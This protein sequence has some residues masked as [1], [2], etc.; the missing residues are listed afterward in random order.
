MGGQDG[1]YQKEGDKWRRLHAG[2]DRVRNV[3]RARDGSLWIA[4]S[5]GVHRY[6]NGDWITNGIEEGLPSSVA[7]KV[8]QDSRGRIWAGTTRGLSLFNPGSDTDPP[9]VLMAD[10]QNA[11]EAPPGGKI[12][13]QFSGED[14]WKMTLPG[15]LLFSWRIDDGGWTP[16]VA[17]TAA[18]WEKLP[19]GPHRFEVRAMDRNGNISRRSAS[20]AFTVLLPWYRMRDFI[21]LATGAAAI[22][23]LLLTLAVLSY[24]KRGDLIRKLNLT[25]KLEHDQQSI[26]ERIARREALPE[27]LQRVVECIAENCPGST[28]ALV[29]N[30]ETIRGVFSQP[31]LPPPLLEA[32][33]KM[34]TAAVSTG[35][36]AGS[37][38]EWWR[39]IDIISPGYSTGRCRVVTLLSGD[40]E[41]A[42][43]VVLLSTGVNGPT[44]RQR[45]VP[46]AFAAIAAAGIENVRLYERLAYQARH[47]VLTGLPNRFCFDD[48]LQSA[49]SAAALNG[50]SLSLLYLDLDRFK[51]INDSLG[52]RAGDLFL[53]QVALRLSEAL[54][55][56]AVLA[57]IGGDEFTVLLETGADKSSVQRLAFAMLNSLRSPIQVEG[58]DLFASASVGASFFPED[59]VTP[60]ALQ[61]HAD[62]AMY[63]AK[64]RGRNCLEF[65]SAEMG[66][67]T[68]AAISL[69]QILR[70]ALEERHFELHYQ[71]QFTRAGALTGFEALLR[72]DDPDRG[73]IGPAEFIPIAEE[74]GLIVPIGAWVVREACRQLRQWQDDGLPATRMSVNISALEIV[75]DSFAD[76]V[77]AAL[78]GE[79]ID[80]R[81][82]ELE[83]TESAIIR[84]PTE[85][86]R[87]M[88][89]AALARN[90]AGYRR[91]RDGLFVLRQSA[92]SSAGHAEDRP[93]FPGG[94]S[95]GRGQ[96]PT[97]A[98]YCGSGAQ[99]GPDRDCRGC[100]DRGAS[101]Y[102]ARKPLR[103]GAGRSVWPPA[104]RVTGP[105]VTGCGA[106]GSDGA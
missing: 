35:S 30:H 87:Q 104:A 91:L 27:I 36:P 101:F 62:I 105:F 42:G 22:I 80:P 75:S 50:Q 34:T 69:E 90:P 10:D 45:G 3:I 103:C 8:F 66:S 70:R 19:A 2:L 92:K 5:T 11:R 43:V 64:A 31:D 49:V 96:S 17:E 25:N 67:V 1:L 106:C 52:H 61:K 71:P 53:A 84:N 37:S 82:L 93:L 29:L 23:I 98:D 57:R 81:F 24:R 26:L 32:L 44:D 33:I 58:Q 63:R 15:R 6:R 88:E 48:R 39:G 73:P 68:E 51:Q 78:S 77:A 40:G 41:V 102:R 60:V 28:C 89:K 79:R 12:R 59:A 7:Y 16:F 54:N 4:S 74:S 99:S 65:F 55:G 21:G 13:F 56:E 72:L 100:G 95:R 76:N 9:V 94:H 18:S 86:V 46:E 85:S 97:D 47:D 20:H 14:R 83:L 38:N